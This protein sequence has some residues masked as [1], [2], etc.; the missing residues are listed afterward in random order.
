MLSIVLIVNQIQNVNFEI[1]PLTIVF[2]KGTASFKSIQQTLKEKL[3][4][5]EHISELFIQYKYYE[6]KDL[7]LYQDSILAYL[8][9]Q[10]YQ[11]LNEMDL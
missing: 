8:L 7:L 11:F 5:Y 9:Q 3:D 1:E 6:N 2:K 10:S 4:S